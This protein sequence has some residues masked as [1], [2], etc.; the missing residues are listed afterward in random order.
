MS[1][2][3]NPHS[4]QIEEDQRRS[5]I[6]PDNE[7]LVFIFLALLRRHQQTGVVFDGLFVEDDEM[8]RDDPLSGS[9]KMLP[10]KFEDVPSTPALERKRILLPYRWPGRFSDSSDVSSIN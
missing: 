2:P 4:L 5:K 1:V 8:L 9:I 10:G 3:T 7:H 6:S